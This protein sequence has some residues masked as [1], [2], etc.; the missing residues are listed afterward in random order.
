MSEFFSQ[1]RI[2]EFCKRVILAAFVTSVGVFLSISGC[3]L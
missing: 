1:F 3:E 2:S